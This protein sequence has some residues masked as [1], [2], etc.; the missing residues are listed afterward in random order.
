[1]NSVPCFETSSY[2]AAAYLTRFLSYE[3]N[4]GQNSSGLGSRSCCHRRGLIK[5]EDVGKLRLIITIIIVVIVT[6]HLG[7]IQAP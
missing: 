6:K 4:N 2:S 1:M 3:C 5:Q 7:S